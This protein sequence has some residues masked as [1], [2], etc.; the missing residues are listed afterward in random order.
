MW[1]LASCLVIANI[2]VTQQ[3]QT[4]ITTQIY[5]NI[6]L[7]QPLNH[8]PTVCQL[9]ERK[10]YKEPGNYFYWFRRS[11]R[12][13]V[14]RAKCSLQNYKNVIKMSTHLHCHSCQ[15]PPESCKFGREKIFSFLPFLS[16]D[17]TL[18][19]ALT[20]GPAVLEGH[21]FLHNGDKAYNHREHL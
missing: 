12:T 10:F 21:W 6:S 15:T 16:L 17:S 19:P 9:S 1:Y 8:G 5:G 3:K 13:A 14:M 20:R 4:H 11:H 7:H 18:H 2:I